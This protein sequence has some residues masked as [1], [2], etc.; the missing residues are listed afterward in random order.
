[1]DVTLKIENEEMLAAIER[2]RGKLP[3]LE[4]IRICFVAGLRQAD[5]EYRR[6]ADPADGR[7]GKA[8]DTNIDLGRVPE[9][10]GKLDA[11]TIMAALKEAN[12]KNPIYAAF[13]EL[14]MKYKAMLKRHVDESGRPLKP[15]FVSLVPI[16]KIAAE[17]AL[18]SVMGDGYKAAATV[19][20][21]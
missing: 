2:L 14:V 20:K 15:F 21:H 19:T 8:R 6:K 4:F 12:K 16:Q 13:Y 17:V 18:R 10:L 9:E 7:T 5:V 11:D 1:M 3:P